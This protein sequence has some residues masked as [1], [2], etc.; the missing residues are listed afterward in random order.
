MGLFDLF[1]RRPA[2]SEGLEQYRNTSGAVLLDVRTPEEYRSGHV[3]GA[4]NLPLDRLGE[5]DLP[6]DRPVFA[7]CLSGARSAQACGWLKRQGYEA[8]NLGGIGSYR[9]PLET[10]CEEEAS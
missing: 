10:K 9:G 6:K 7:Y 1:A 5:L 4:R 8:T 2:L 3:P